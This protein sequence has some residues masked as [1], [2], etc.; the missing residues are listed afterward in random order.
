VETANI[1]VNIIILTTIF[2]V[3]VKSDIVRTPTHLSKDIMFLKH[4]IQPVP[5][6]KSDK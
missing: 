2:E 5:G 4:N 1:W 6:D 3:F